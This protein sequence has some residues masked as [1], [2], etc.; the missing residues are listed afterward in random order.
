MSDDIIRHVETANGDTGSLGS[1]LCRKCSNNLATSCGLRPV[2]CVRRYTLPR[3]QRTGEA[4]ERGS[5]FN[6]YGFG[7]NQR[8]IQ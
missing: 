3:Y 2:R 5:S 6:H 8:T 1:Y 7:D 4:K